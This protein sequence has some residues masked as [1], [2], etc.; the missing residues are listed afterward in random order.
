MAKYLRSQSPN[1]FWTS[2]GPPGCWEWQGGRTANGG[3]GVSRYGGKFCR[4]HRKAWMLLNGP[5][6]EGMLV[7][8]RCGNAACVR[9]DH[10]YVGSNR[11]NMIDRAN[12]DRQDK[13][14]WK[15]SPADAAEIRLRYATGTV[16]QKDLGEVYGVS[17]HAVSSI[18]R[19]KSYRPDI[20]HRANR[21][22]RH[23]EVTA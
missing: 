16:T 10:L 11:D 23:K 19:G 12:K 7:L 18:V 4:A 13:R 15:L 2:A 20:P 5:I 3:Y 1:S 21:H 9:P 8:H 14:T 22:Q 6:P 17:Q